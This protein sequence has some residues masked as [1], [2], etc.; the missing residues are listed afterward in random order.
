MKTQQTPSLQMCKASLA[1][2]A[3][4]ASL[5]LSTNVLAGSLE[6]AT[7]TKNPHVKVIKNSIGIELIQVQSGEFL[8][9]GQSSAEK[10]VNEFPDSKVIAATLSDEYPQH[11][12]RISKPFFLGKYEVTVGQF[13]QFTQDT[14]YKTEAEIDGTGGWGYNSETRKSEGRRQQFNWQNTGYPQTDKFPVVNV[15]YNDALAF[16]A[17]L[18]A[19]EGKHYRLPTEAEWEY[20]NRAGTK[21]LY[22]NG[23]DPKQIPKF[24]RST[25]VTLHPDFAHVQDL[26]VSP[27]DPTAFPVNVG[28]YAPNPWG[29]YDMHGNAWEWV[30]DWYSD[31]Y[32]AHSSLVDPQGPST[33][34][35]R[36]RRGGGW[37]SFPVWLRSSFR[38]INT[39]SSRCVNLGFRVALDL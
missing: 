38:N 14:G 1:I 26:E 37:N 10:V 2:V 15:S 11:R 23:N 29:F 13:R 31:S 9:G 35:V 19:K 4:F 32:Y 7:Q 33:G 30:S 34:D 39:P 27:D 20:A 36:V 21:T 16:L 3:I 22:S 25:D 28:S 18:S 8:M 6:K 12:V 5:Y 17:W 24:A